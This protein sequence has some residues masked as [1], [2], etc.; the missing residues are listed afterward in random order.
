MAL[1]KSP[2][3]PSVVASTRTS[4][5]RQALA[6]ACVPMRRSSRRPPAPVRVAGWSYGCTASRRASPRLWA[7]GRFADKN[8]WTHVSVCVTASRPHS[9]VRIQFYDT[10][11]TPS[12]G[13]DAVDLR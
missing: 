3:Q 12:L 11:K 4:P 1:E 6:R 2:L 10:P 7:S 9:D 13:L 8:R 5:C